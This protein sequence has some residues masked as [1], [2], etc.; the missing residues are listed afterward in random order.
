MFKVRF[1]PSPTGYLHI[2]GAR[3]ALFNKIAA[4]KLSGKFVLRI[5]DTDLTR[6]DS[7]MSDNIIKS[8]TWLGITWDEGPYYQSQRLDIYKKYAETL[9]EKGLAY[10]CICP[11]R[12][13]SEPDSNKH[14]S[15]NQIWKYDRKC[16]GLPVSETVKSQ[17]K[18]IR[19]K[20]PD[21]KKINFNDICLGNVEFNSSELDDF[22]ILKSDGMP[23]YNFAVVIDDSLMNISAVIRGNDHLSNTPKQILL[24]NALNMPVPEFCHMPL[25]LGKDKKRLSKRHGAVSVEWFKENGF[26]PE[27]VINYI[28]LL[29]WSPP[30]NKEIL[31]YSEI[32]RLFDLNKIGKKDAVFDYEKLEWMNAKYIMNSAPE[33]L[34][35]YL[36][37]EIKSELLISHDKEYCC[38]VIKLFQPRAK[39]ITDII[40]NADYFFS[41][42]FKYD[43]NAVNKYFYEN[44]SAEYLKKMFDVFSNSDF[45]NPAILE[46]ELRTLSEKLSVKAGILIH[47]LRVCV[48]G[49]SATPGI[50]D[51]LFILGKEK[52][53]SRIKRGISFAEAGLNAKF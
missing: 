46:T 19:F 38:S 20:T 22:I 52:I 32:V 21:N 23:A 53:L 7:N 48:S 41:H 11:Q 1:A 24:Y 8:L 44:N 2:G 13:E 43:E 40:I 26:L 16:L 27:A 51:I 39:R 49:K 5:E 31:N 17:N 18:V 35:S 10:Y 37:K 14:S 33:K 3:T 29:G 36:I 12:S 6:S 25:I 50:F 47:L 34:Y 4:D 30:D 45:S 15:K 28:S 42:N 9:I